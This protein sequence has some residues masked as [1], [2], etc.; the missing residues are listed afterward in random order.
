MQVP[1][2]P[3]PVR[4]GP[5][6]LLQ[7][8]ATGGMAEIY[9]ARREGP[10]GF[11]KR[12]ALKRILPQLAADPEF[13]AMFIDEARLCAQLTHPNLVQVFDFGEEEGELYMAMELVE[14]TTGA[15][16]ARAAA[17]RGEPVPTEV[18]LYIAL[19]VG[20]GLAHAHEACDEEGRPL[21]LVHRDVSPGNILI[22]RAGAVKLADFGIAR[23][24]EFERR[25]D[26]GQLKGKLGYMSPEQVTGRELDAKSD[27]FTAAIVLAEL[28]TARPLF[29][30]Q[31]EMDVL[32]KIRDAE[33]S[34]LDR[35]GRH[36][37]GD[38]MAVLK[39]ALSRRR[40]ERFPTTSE[41]VEALDEVVRARRLGAGPAALVEWLQRVGLVKAVGKSGEH[42]IEGFTQKTPPGDAP[43]STKP[44]G[45]G[46]SK[47]SGAQ[48]IAQP[49]WKG[50]P[51]SSFNPL[52]QSSVASPVYR[53]D[54]P[55]MKTGMSL[56]E[57]LDIIGSG[58]VPLSVRVSRDSGPFKPALEFAELARACGG[59]AANWD[60][61]VVR[62]PTVVWTLRPGELPPRLFDLVIA[63]ATGMLVVQNG[64]VQKKVFFVD[65]VPEVTISTDERELLGAILVER[66]LALPMEIEM[67]LAMAPRHGGR[68]GDALV[69]LGVLRPMELVR[70]VVDQMKRRFIELVGWKTGQLTFT[71]DVRCPDE[72]TVPEAF[73]PFELIAR[74][75]V[76]GYSNDDLSRLLGP[77]ENGLLVPLPR[78]PVSAGS[79][80]L[81]APETA[82]LELIKG[83][84]TL[85]EI[86]AL[87]AQRGIARD[88]V[89]RGVFVGLASGAFVSPAWP[90]KYRESLPTLP[91]G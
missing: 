19:S 63:R 32:V 41:Y 27:Q 74:G 6:E 83:Q 31:R 60:D 33:V 28:L 70:A 17:S 77:L 46:S 45:D 58:R 53:I 62:D 71:I 40:E 43:P 2:S 72:E 16:V 79:L 80:K 39:R 86:T 89:L 81:D 36:I 11:S 5:Y 68:L 88:A 51:V 78:A 3:T 49:V 15:K 7:K 75:I 64:G 35:H 21:G 4:L 87:A 47:A 13:V 57:L 48:P 24:A 52:P 9:I 23:A 22:S 50:V 10:H 65:G 69:R 82:V 38:L 26:Q 59:P 44:T 14:G 37:P 1:Y 12:I 54:T 85:A 8:L 30:G 76:A 25:T 42:F 91:H 66:G 34:A 20:R 90:T 29:S 84:T 18:A 61:A 55:G 73:N 56:P 67:G